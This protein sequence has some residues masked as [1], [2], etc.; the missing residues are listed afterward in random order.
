MPVFVLYRRPSSRHPAII[1]DL[2]LLA[3]AGQQ[4]AVDAA[5]SM[6]ADLFRHG[7]HSSYAKKLQSLPIWELKTHAR[8]G[9]K[10]GMRVYFF[11]RP[12]GSAH[13]VNAESKDGN[14]PGPTLKEALRAWRADTS[15][16]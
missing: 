1:E 10:G 12:D 15:G 7:H 11:F 16:D 8:G 5:V 9:A 3:E 14:S 4:H 6:L 2:L 13:I